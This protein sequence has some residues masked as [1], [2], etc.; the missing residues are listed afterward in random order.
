MYGLLV[1]FYKNYIVNQQF[2]T[3]VLRFYTIS[4]S[5][6]SLLSPVFEIREL[7]LKQNNNVKM[8]FT[9]LM[10]FPESDFVSFF[11]DPIFRPQVPFYEEGFRI[12]CISPQKC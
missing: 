10:T 5:F 7:K 1:F 6:M 9:I 2:N 3:P 11:K 8:N 4:R 12:E